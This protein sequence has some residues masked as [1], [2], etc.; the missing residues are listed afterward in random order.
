MTTFPAMTTPRETQGIFRNAARALSALGCALALGPLGCGDG[1]GGAATGGEAPGPVA[2]AGAERV[3]ISGL[4]FSVP[5]QWQSQPPSTSMRLAEYT[6]PGPAGAASLVVYRFPGGGSAKANVDRWIGQFQGANGAS[7]RDTAVVQSSERGG[8]TLTSLDVS[9][10]YEGTQMPGAPAQP[11]I[12]D[13]RLLALVVE[14]R[15]D[16]YFFKLQGPA[17][18]VG[19]WVEAWAQ[20]TASV[21]TE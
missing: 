20:L 19:T 5:E 17:G 14:G 11:A 18:T 4:A 7:A 1:D 13:A 6:V 10:R 15:D 21:Q 2:A 16:P 3:A 12:A 9:G 8:L